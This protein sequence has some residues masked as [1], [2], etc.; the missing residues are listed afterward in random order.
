MPIYSK[1]G[2]CYS[3][4]YE[5]QTIRGLTNIDYNDEVIFYHH[6]YDKLQSNIS[7]YN[8]LDEANWEYLRN[9]PTVKLVHDNDSETFEIYFV[10]DVVKT[11]TERNIQPSQLDITVMDENHKAFLIEN[12]AKFNITEVQV[13]VRNYLLNHIIIPTMRYKF[14]ALSRNYRLWRLFVYFE[15]AKRE[16]LTHFNYSFHNIHPYNNPPVVYSIDKMVNDL[17]SIGVTDIP[18]NVMHWLEACPHELAESNQVTNKWSNV[19]YD[20]INSADFHLIIETHFDQKEYVLGSKEFD[21][22]FSPSSVT[23]KCYKPI[24][25]VRPFI[26]FST[27]YYLEDL[28]K[29]GFKTFSPFIDESYDRE[30]N[31]ITRVNMIVEEINRICLLNKEDY[32]ALVD[33]CRMIAVENLEILKRKQNAP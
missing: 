12:L 4:D 15:L 14:S 26:A 17:T 8:A 33:N 7:L 16:L 30:T 18:N 3:H 5:Y 1:T 9:N 24:A 31:S 21:R 10:E 19:T 27:P 11:L 6:P 29:L 32:S 2:R 25:C 20:T 13:K 28:R 22:N 23:E